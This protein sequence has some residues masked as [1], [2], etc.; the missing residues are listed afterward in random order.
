MKKENEQ[1]ISRIWTPHEHHVFTAIVSY[2]RM[3]KITVKPAEIT[4]LY[5][6]IKEI[7]IE[8]SIPIVLTNK[9]E[10]QHHSKLL[11]F[12]KRKE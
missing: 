12:L 2:L 8:D 10:A 6:K 5:T 7:T 1:T 4:T 9:T 3:K 11:H